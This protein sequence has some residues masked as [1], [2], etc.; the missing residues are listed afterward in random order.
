MKKTFL[1]LLLAALFALSALAGTAA[2]H[3]D[4]LLQWEDLVVTAGTLRVR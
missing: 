4:N 3:P 2:V 1:L